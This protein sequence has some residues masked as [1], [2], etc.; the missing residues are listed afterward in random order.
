LI[1]VSQLL[2]FGEKFWIKVGHLQFIVI[3]IA[4]DPAPSQTWGEAYGSNHSIYLSAFPYTSFATSEHEIALDG[5]LATHAYVNKFINMHSPAMTMGIQ[6][7]SAQKH[8]L[9]YIGIYAAIG[10]STAFVSV[11]SYVAQFTGA[12]RASRL[13]FRRLLIGVVKATMRW[14]DVTPQ[15]W[16]LYGLCDVS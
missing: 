12:L 6:W 9:F 7:P 8:P 15:G 1:V 3:K 14:H 16:C 2:G 4:T 5:H 13:L 11:A 10:L